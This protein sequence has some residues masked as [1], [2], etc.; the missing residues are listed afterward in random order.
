MTPD[1]LD[2]T[3]E[4][5]VATEEEMRDFL[6]Q[7]P[8]Q[9]EQLGDDSLPWSPEEELLVVR[10]LLQ[11]Q[12]TGEH[13]VLSCI[14]NFVLFAAIASVIYSLMQTTSVRPH[15]ANGVVPEKL[16]V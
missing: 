12:S 5:A 1:E 13:S 8:N 2:S 15:A 14:R 9:T 4:D 6:N 7:A 3:G 16:L 10:P 11:A